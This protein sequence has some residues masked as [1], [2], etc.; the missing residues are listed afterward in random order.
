M[1]EV[2]T[3]PVRRVRKN[4]TETVTFDDRHTL[5]D[6]A[7]WIMESRGDA[8]EIHYMLGQMLDGTFAQV[9]Q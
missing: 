8:E 5:A 2:M 6:I 9:M 3:P 7:R 4:G 1:S